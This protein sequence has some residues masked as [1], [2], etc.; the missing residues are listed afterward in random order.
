MYQPNIPPVKLYDNQEEGSGSDAEEK[1]RSL[2]N[3]LLDF[4]DEAYAGLLN[5]QLGA[6]YISDRETPVKERLGLRKPSSL[7]SESARMPVLGIFTNPLKLLGEAGDYILLLS[8]STSMFSNYTTGRP[9]GNGKTRENMHEIDFPKSLAGVPLSPEVNYFFQSE[10]EYLYSGHENAAKNLNTVTRLI[11]M[12]RMVCN[13]ITVF[14]VRDVT[15]IIDG[16]YKAFKWSLPLSIV[17]AELARLAFVAAESLYDVAT[18]R[19]G[20]KVPLFKSPNDWTCSP[21]GIQKALKEI[22]AS[23]KEPD[24]MPKKEKGLAYHNYM[25]LFF[26]A[27]V[28][29]PSVNAGNELAVRTGK[30]I[31]WNVINYRNNIN[32]DESKMIEVLKN[33]DRFRLSG[34]KT[35]FSITT[36]AELRMLF[37]S[38]IFAQ[39]FSNSRGIG[40]PSSFPVTVT[41]H[42]GY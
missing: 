5:D 7:I 14:F 23:N 12:L 41:D 18:L 3:D 32:S 35:D 38:M 25:L 19:T 31:E 15:R 34:M 20:S 8:Y 22:K 17:L 21:K 29:S 37:F 10:L 28:L 1:Q 30:L 36:N 27:K 11:F 16:I 13:Y 42:R 33:E 24:G 26:L 9:E 4:I 39:N 40:M 2:I 6:K